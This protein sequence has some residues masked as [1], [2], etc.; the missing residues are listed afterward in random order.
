MVTVTQFKAKCLG[1]ITEVERNKRPI[2]I[3]KNGRIVAQLVPL[4]DHG[5]GGCFGR[6]KK[7]TKIHGDLLT[8]GE[9]WDVED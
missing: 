1:L 7:T 5:K 3:T 6:A 9:H 4:S 8:T 2:A